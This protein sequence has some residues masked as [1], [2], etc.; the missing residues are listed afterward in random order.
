MTHTM[1][2]DK[3]LEHNAAVISTWHGRSDAVAYFMLQP[4]T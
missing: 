3:P 1:E 2:S 4:L